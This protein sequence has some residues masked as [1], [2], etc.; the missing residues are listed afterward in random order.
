ME[1][2][3]YPAPHK[4]IPRSR[5]APQLTGPTNFRVRHYLPGGGP[6]A[7]SKSRNTSSGCDAGR[8]F[9]SYGFVRITFLLIVFHSLLNSTYSEVV[10]RG[11]DEDS[12]RYK[13]QKIELNWDGPTG[14]ALRGNARIT[15]YVGIK[16]K[17]RTKR[18]NPR[19]RRTQGLF[20]TAS[21]GI[22]ISSSNSE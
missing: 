17:A 3:D 11:E 2:W 13:P 15:T 4:S 12:T 21:S 6:A 18:N 16:R 9:C 22:S 10:N 8:V 19:R 5:N 7:I 14:T 20:L 1:V